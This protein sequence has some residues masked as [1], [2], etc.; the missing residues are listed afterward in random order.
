MVMTMELR[1][2]HCR[3]GNCGLCAEQHPAKREIYVEGVI[4]LA[5]DAAAYYTAV[6]L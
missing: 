6:S 5:L 1:S 3:S 4:E 2:F